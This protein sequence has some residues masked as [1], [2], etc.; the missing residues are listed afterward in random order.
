MAEA[1]PQHLTLPSGLL[2]SGAL[3]GPSRDSLR[4]PEQ[5]SL[6]QGVSSPSSLDLEVLSVFVPPFVSKEDSPTAGAPSA[7]LSKTRRRS[8][9][10]KRDKPKTEPW[11]GLP[12]EDISVPN[13]VDL[14][15]L[16]QLCFPGG[17]YVASEPKE[18]CV[19]FLVLTDVCGNRTYA[20]VAQYYR[21]LHDESCFYNGKAHWEPSWPTAGRGWLLRTVRVWRGLQAPYYN[22]LKDCLSW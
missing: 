21:P 10:K 22:A 6:K 4:G 5:V 16:P 2:E 18:D 13:G 9:R 7:T 12:P 17:V 14:L 1:A 11:K 3:L 20:V 8:F 19:H 15:G